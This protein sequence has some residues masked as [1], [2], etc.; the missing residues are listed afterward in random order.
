MNRYFQASEG[1]HREVRWGLTSLNRLDDDRDETRTGKKLG[2]VRK[3]VSV[4]RG[5]C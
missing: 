2:M 1:Q 3:V 4:S 5:F